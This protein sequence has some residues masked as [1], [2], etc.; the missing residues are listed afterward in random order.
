MPGTVNET[1]GDGPRDE[2]VQRALE[3]RLAA[4][5]S[6]LAAS[7]AQNQRLTATLR[8]A[9]DQIVTLRE[10]VDRLAQ[11]PSGFGVFLEDHGDGTSDIFTAGRKLRVAVS[12][13]VDAAELRRG[14][15]VML[16]EAMVV[17]RALE[18][19]T[20]GEVGQCSRRSSRTA[21]APSSSV[22]PTRNASSAW[23]AP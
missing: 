23:P 4:I 5:Q 16:N 7:G 12:P 13:E 10:E 18:F 11:P 21:C 3:E 19:E 22:T 1:S 15:E 2:A 17:I 8:E 9:R 20:V 14:Q 6:E